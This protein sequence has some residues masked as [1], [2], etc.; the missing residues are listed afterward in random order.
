MLLSRNDTYSSTTFTHIIVGSQSTITNTTFLASVSD[1]D[2]SGHTGVQI[3]SDA[4]GVIVANNNFTRIGTIVD[5]GA[6]ST[7]NI[8]TGN[9]TNDDGIT[10]VLPAYTDLSIN[11]NI[12]PNYGTRKFGA[13]LGDTVTSKSGLTFNT[14]NGISFSATNVS[15][16]TNYV[17]MFAGATGSPAT[18]RALGGDTDVDLRLLPQG[19]GVVRFGVRLGTADVPVT[20]YM[21]IKDSGGTV[22]KVAIID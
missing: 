11:S 7:Q 21:T 5:M 14:L 4:R 18:I 12:G 3:V 17:D 20:G 15:S 1:P 10:N 22:R 9:T 19:A 13:L 2:T 8:I 6:G 16:P